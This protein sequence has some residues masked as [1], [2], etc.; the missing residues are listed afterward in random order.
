MTWYIENYK[1]HKCE[2]EALELLAST[3]N[4]LA[5]IQWRIDESLRLIW[6][7]D[8][9]TPT[10]IRPIS[11]RYPNRFPY[12]PPLVLPRGDMTRWSG[13]Q[14]GRGGE[15]CLEYGPDN[16]H[17]DLTGADMV[18]SAHRL[19]AGEEPTP[20]VTTEV[21]S[22]HQTTIGQDLRGRFSRFLLTRALEEELRTFPEGIVALAR[23]AGMYHPN[24]CA[25]R[26]IAS[27]TLP[28]GRIWNDELPDIETLGFEQCVA[29]FRWPGDQPFP[30]TGSLT[31]FRQAIAQRGLELTGMP[32]AVV[33][34]GDKTRA[35][36]LH[37]ESETL[38]ES[39]II[40]PQPLAPRLD[41]DHVAL[42][43]RK[44]AIVGC[45][46]LGSKVAVTLARSGV[47]NFL[48]V[49]DDLFSPDN[50]VRHDLDW[51]EV[52][53]HKANG[54][55]GRIQLVNPA[56]KCSVRRHRLGGQESSGALEDL[57]ESL[58]DCDTL[59]DATAESGVFNY[60]CAVVAVSKKPMVWAEVF[61]GGFG[62]LIAR[63]RPGREP[64]PASMRCIIENWCGDQG[65]LMPRPAHRYGGEPHAPAIAD[66]ADVAVIAGHA[67]RMVIDLLI[68]R[69][70]SIFPPFRLSS[71]ARRR[72]DLR[73]AF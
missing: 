61:G 55:A 10:V 73:A 36:Y 56:A 67:A 35:F 42:R 65:K 34:H 54:V 27:I 32:Y 23:T 4:W 22:R 29:L 50:I 44:V 51:R 66:D 45:G 72:L 58:A 48:L 25:V 49:D 7:A 60:L 31:E 69:D 64:D 13:H 14:F 15:L 3:E 2:R 43:E 11:L 68:P 19:L 53:T 5:P 46:S 59:M 33:I 12:S 9:V 38:S 63:H 21:A 41:S 52:G 62:G 28:D 20:G 26:V 37:V 24:D 57:I 47:A 30:P 17:Q 70:P 40:P 18:A 6:D 39:A 8:I 16:W 71:G 1:L